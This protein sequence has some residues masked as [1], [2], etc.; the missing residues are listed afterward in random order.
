MKQKLPRVTAN[1]ASRALEKSGFVVV[2]QS[3]S[4]RIYKNAAGR[5]ITVPFHGSRTLHPKLIRAILRDAEITV[6]RFK[7]LSR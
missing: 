7:L 2:R 3:G 4:H 5:R 6:D 1:E